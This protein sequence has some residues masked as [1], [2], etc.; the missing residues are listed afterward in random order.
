MKFGIKG[1]ILTAVLFSSM[2]LFGKPKKHGTT[3]LARKRTMK[4]YLKQARNGTINWTAIS[5]LPKSFKP[6]VNM[7]DIYDVTL[8]MYAASPVGLN[9]KQQYADSAAAAHRLVQLG[10]NKG[11]RSQADWTASQYAT[12]AARPKL[13]MYLLQHNPITRA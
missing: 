4:K 7:G 12:S 3:L 13:A 11:L 8:L 9:T 5:K 6:V 1:L 10:A 2:P